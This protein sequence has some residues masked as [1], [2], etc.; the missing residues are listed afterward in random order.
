MC[1]CLFMCVFMCLCLRASACVHVSACL[2]V[3]VCL[4][5]SE[6]VSQ[7]C[8]DSVPTTLWFGSLVDAL[9]SV[10]FWEYSPT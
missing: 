7:Q 3:C 10:G 2:R 5:L 9:K 8:H 1:V 4:Y 6:F